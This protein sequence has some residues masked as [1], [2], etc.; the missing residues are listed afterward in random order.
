MF[1][2]IIRIWSL[3]ESQQMPGTS[4]FTPSAVQ[5]STLAERAACTWGT[6]SGRCVRCIAPF[7]LCRYEVVPPVQNNTQSHSF[8]LQRLCM[9]YFVLHRQ[10]QFAA[11]TETLCAA[12]QVV[13]RARS[14]VQTE[15][16]GVVGKGCAAP[17]IVLCSF[18]NYKLTQL[19]VSFETQGKPM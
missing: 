7:C 19:E 12:G 16:F 14:P 18:G 13:Q 1:V 10:L 8:D 15:T 11:S 3:D 9:R 4:A 2:R 17:S 5:G 6:L